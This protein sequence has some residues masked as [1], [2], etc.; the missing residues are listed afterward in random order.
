MDGPCPLAMKLGYGPGSTLAKECHDDQMVDTDGVG[1]TAA[2]PLVAGV[3]VRS[4]AGSVVPDILSKGRCEMA[5]VQ[6][7][8]TSAQLSL[9]VGWWWCVSNTKVCI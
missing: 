7:G 9:K 5:S 8:S 4:Y 2:A 1:F 6:D 3:V